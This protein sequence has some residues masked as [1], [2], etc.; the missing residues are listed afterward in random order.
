MAKMS[1]EQ[2]TEYVRIERHPPPILWKYRPWNIHTRSMI[3][4]GELWFATVAELND[5]FEFR[6]Q[7]KF[8]TDPREQRRFSNALRDMH[9]PGEDKTKRKAILEIFWRQVRDMAAVSP[10]GIVPSSATKPQGVFCLSEVCND[11]L[12]WSHYADRHRGICVGIRTD[13]IPASRFAK[14]QYCDDIPVLDCWEYVKSNVDR[15]VKLSLAKATRWQYE[16]EWRT[17]HE[18]GKHLARGC[19]DRII[20]G[21]CA[22]DEM[23][24][25]VHQ[26]IRESGCKIKVI[27][28]KLSPTAYALEIPG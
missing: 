21:A 17:V 3:T 26:A 8:P 4:G 22:T 20:I 12:M 2:G 11:V 13:R 23:K 18:P 7:D 5:P 14:V 27:E 1:D 9:F 15:F 19:V 10:D 24:K 16:K 28:A 25:D 6:W